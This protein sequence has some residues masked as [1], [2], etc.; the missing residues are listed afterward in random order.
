MSHHRLQTFESPNS[1]NDT[2]LI[3]KTY[4]NCESIYKF[5]SSVF[6][7]VTQTCKELE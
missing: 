7:R 5:D 3:D 1:K 4:V 2:S 6:E